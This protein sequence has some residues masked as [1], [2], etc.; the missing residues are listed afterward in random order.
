M[1]LKR[2]STSVLLAVIISMSAGN[3]S[4]A[5]EVNQ[6]SQPNQVNQASTRGYTAPSDTKSI[7]LNQNN[8]FRVDKNHKTEWC[9]FKVTENGYITLDVDKALFAGNQEGNVDVIMQDESGNHVYLES[10]N[11]YTKLGDSTKNTWKIGLKPGE[12]YMRLNANFSTGETYM[13]LSYKVRFTKDNNFET[14][15]YLRT[16]NLN[17]KYS[18]IM[19]EDGKAYWSNDTDDYVFN[20]SGKG[21]YIFNINHG[22]NKEYNYEVTDRYDRTVASF[23]SIDMNGN[24]GRNYSYTLKNLTPGEYK[25][26]IYS[27]YAIQDEYTFSI[28][29]AKDGW[30][31][32]DGSWY[33]YKEGVKQTDWQTIDGKDYFFDSTGKMKTGWFNDYGTWYYLSSN[34][35]K[36]KGWL[37]LGGTWYYLSEE[38][39]GMQTGLQYIDGHTYYFYDNGVM[40]NKGWKKIDGTYYY[41]NQS[42]SAKTG[43]L[44]EGNNWYYLDYDGSMVKGLQYIDGKTYFFNSGGVMYNKPGW[45][46][47]NGS[48][49]Y[50]NSNGTAKTG[51]YKEGSTWYYLYS[52]GE[53]ATG[54]V[55]IGG[56]SYIFSDYGKMRTG[57]I[58]YYG[59]TYYANS[60]GTLKRGWYKEKGKWYYFHD[61]YNYMLTG[62]WYINGIYNY[63]NENGVWQY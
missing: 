25:L 62:G 29:K 35:V 39:G 3:L 15:G 59:S 46:N 8:V 41:F 61:S 49:Y 5:N 63:F 54:K 37:N 2:I 36:Q 28:D 50:F 17:T 26:K 4:N 19:N 48:Y 11:D 7:N 56:A 34:G 9:K 53:M 10:D 55:Q 58:N 18:V 60:N 57:W 1:N 14:E 42:G 24:D 38:D 6:S 20:V 40:F 51:W 22:L 32:E 33:Y 27:Y 16:I 13:D 21:H 45:K 43:W 47:I 52:D 30:I 12:Y 23:D 31:Q 44:K